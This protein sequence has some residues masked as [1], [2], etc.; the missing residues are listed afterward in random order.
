LYYLFFLQH[1]L[2]I[3]SDNGVKIILHADF[4]ELP[5]AGNM[6]LYTF[7]TDKLEKIHEDHNP[8]RTSLVVTASRVPELQNILNKYRIYEIF[9]S[10]DSTGLN[11][12]N[13]GVRINENQ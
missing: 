5:V 6:F 10:G 4:G 8:Y 1:I 12:T 9:I 11:I 2:T 13:K 3:L 7:Y